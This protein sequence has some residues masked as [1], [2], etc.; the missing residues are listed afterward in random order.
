MSAAQE[1]A[2]L[3]RRVMMTIGRGRVTWSND[4]GPIQKLQATLMG[5]GDEI[6]DNLPRMAEYGFT[7]NPPVGTDTLVVFIGGDRSNGAVIGTNN[8]AARKK[9][10]VVGEVAMYDDQGQCVHIK[11]DGIYITTTKKVRVDG[12]DI[13]FH[14]SHSYSWDVAGFGERWT[15][16]GGTTWEHKT[17]QAGATVNSI[18]N[19]INPPDGS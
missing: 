16:T 2:R 13:Q 18:T 1:I 10:L 4:D 11:R 12:A 7:S 17:W 8:Q 14:A 5:G 3:F 15:W 6:R 9:G 19:S